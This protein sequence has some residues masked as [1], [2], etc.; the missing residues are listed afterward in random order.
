M[1]PSPIAEL[2]GRV[3]G[4]RY[5]LSRPLGA[6][7]SAHV[8]VAD[9]VRLRRRVAVKVLHPALA[10]DEAFLRRFEAEA[11]VVAGLR[12]PHILR[13]YDWGDDEGTPYLVTELLEGG[14][15]RS[16]LDRGH[17]L[18]PAQAARLGA[19][20]ARALDYA[21]G[22]GLVHRDIKPA[23]LLFDEEGRVTVADFG[24]A[25]ALAEATW[26]E[27]AGAVLGTARYAAPEAVRG[28]TLDDRADVYAL[29]LTLVEATT[30]A[31]PFGTDTT[32]GTLM[33]RL[34]HP[35]VV[36]ADLGPLGAVLEEAGRV[37]PSDR[38]D[39]GALAGAFDRVM[40]VLP[41][42]GLLP[43]AGPLATGDADRDDYPTELTRPR[44]Q[45]FDIDAVD[46]RQEAPSPPTRSALPLSGAD[47]PHEE[48]GDRRRR[49]R[50]PI[51]ILVVVLLAAALT[52]AGFALTRHPPTHPVPL[53][54]GKDQTTA[55]TLLRPLHLHL[56][57]SDHVYNATAK[58]G[59]IVAQRP[60][61]GRLSEGKAVSVTVSRGPQPVAVP[62]LQGHTYD[63]AVALLTGSGLKAGTKT[64]GRSMTVTAGSVISS[65]PSSGTLL[66]GQSVNLVVSTG[67]PTVPVPALAGP[68]ASS[69]G[70]AQAALAAAN[71]GA[72]ET[73]AHN[74][75]VPKGQVISTTPPAGTSVT[76]QAVVTVVISLGP[77][78]VTVPS[79]KSLSVTAASQALSAVG[80]QVSGVT[81]NPTAA[82]TGST[83]PAGALVHRGGAVQL[84]TS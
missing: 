57:V 68:Q 12:H 59:V 35:L 67:K 40:A 43:L 72:T 70:A 16:L 37:L 60:S 7:A 31:V 63:D 29:A 77:D 65:S 26:T 14:S 61:G 54:T 66:P 28:E 76:V 5:R 33:G 13:V 19:D 27:P 2:V 69:F 15:L 6:G 22:R 82:V 20:V 39:A 25:R 21:H 34:A 30:G 1:A 47:P 55:Q 84:T 73:L 52:A 11:R 49:R 38:P 46:N 79:V 24:L 53:L 8:Y 32:V 18:S 36:D 81:G 64:T 23:N 44:P 80:F 3:L 50:Q 45:L 83:P 58:S 4:G 41:A 48:A 74:D 9:D 51:A 75:R 78:L 62:A 42:P 71:L 10:G 56:V 17:L